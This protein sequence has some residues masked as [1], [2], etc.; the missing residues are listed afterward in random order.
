VIEIEKLTDADKGRKVIYSDNHGLR[1]R[2]MISSWNNLYVFVRFHAG[3]AACG[4]ES[5]SFCD[6]DERMADIVRRLAEWKFS[7]DAALL[8]DHAAM[9][10]SISDDAQ[11][12]WDA[13]RAE[14]QP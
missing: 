12:L 2:G 7:S 10:D 5:L 3:T 1:E 4:P 6:L 11:A 8:N 14:V 13:Y 9:I